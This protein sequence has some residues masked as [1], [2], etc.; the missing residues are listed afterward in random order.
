MDK[1]IVIISLIVIFLILVVINNLLDLKTYFNKKVNGGNNKKGENNDYIMVNTL[2]S[3]DHYGFWKK[4]ENS[5]NTHNARW[6]RERQ[7]EYL[8]KEIPTVYKYKNTYTCVGYGL[9]N[10]IFIVLEDGVVVNDVGTDTKQGEEMIKVIKDVTNKPVKY[11]IFGHNHIDHTGGIGAYVKEWPELQIIAHHNI[12]YNIKNTSQVISNILGIRSAKHAGINVPDELFD[13][14]GIGPHKEVN[15]EFS[16]YKSPDIILGNEDKEIELC[17]A[18]FIFMWAPSETDDELCVYLPESKILLTNE[19][20]NPSAPSS[21]TLRGTKRRDIKVWIESLEKMLDKF[22][23]SE[24]MTPTHGRPVIE[25]KRVMK[26][27]SEYKDGALSM[28]QQTMKYMNEGKEPDEIEHLVK[29]PDELNVPWNYF[30]HYNF[31][32]SFPKAIYQNYLGHYNGDPYTLILNKESHPHQRACFWVR[33]PEKVLIEVESL[34]KKGEKAFAVELLTNLI[35]CPSVSEAIKSE[36]K[37]RKA[38][39]YLQLAEEQTSSNLR[40]WLITD[41]LLLQNKIEM[42]PINFNVK[43]LS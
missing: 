34:V 3:N 39:L 23:E 16:T 42:K 30:D 13:H 37:K 35:K 1:L 7:S 40:N 19:I 10:S 21:Y 28:Y 4:Y 6:I 38:E 33:N 20:I 25:N 9:A 12:T 32:A 41:A 8:H 14:A 17:G 36:S 24:Y 27:I 22:S 18:K 2:K 29:V 43:D 31:Q 15:T 26:R 11:V 5:W